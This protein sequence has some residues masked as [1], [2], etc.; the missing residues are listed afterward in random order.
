MTLLETR[1]K[2]TDFPINSHSCQVQS[3]NQIPKF[4]FISSYK[5][6]TWLIE[7]GEHKKQMEKCTHNS[8]IK[9]QQSKNLGIHHL[10][11][12]LMYQNVFHVCFQMEITITSVNSL[13]LVLKIALNITYI[14]PCSMSLQTVQNSLYRIDFTRDL[15]VLI[16]RSCQSS[17][18]KGTTMK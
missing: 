8:I 10:D 11:Y 6:S 15:S 18:S 5:I 4:S 7:V 12:F 17:S 14:S 9:L 16:L 3:R 1:L 2:Q 13:W